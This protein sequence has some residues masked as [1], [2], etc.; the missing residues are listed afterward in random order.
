MR[1]TGITEELNINASYDA[2]F[3]VEEKIINKE[4]LIMLRAQ[5]LLKVHRYFQKKLHLRLQVLA[6]AELT[7]DTKT[8]VPQTRVHLQSGTQHLQT[9]HSNRTKS[10]VFSSTE[11][12]SYCRQRPSGTEQEIKNRTARSHA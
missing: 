4:Y 7:E 12:L 8:Q 3:M 1:G 6:A 9:E 10:T 5:S 2:I 11:S